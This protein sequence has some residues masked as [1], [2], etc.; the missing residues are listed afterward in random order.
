[1]NPMA[2]PLRI[3]TKFIGILI[4]A[5]VLPVTAALFVFET[6]GYRSYR[7]ARGRL[8]QARAEHLAVMLT[9]LVRQELESLEDWVALSDLHERVAQAEET[10]RSESPEERKT[11]AEAIEA[12][13]PSMDREDP[14]VRNIISNDIAGRLNAFRSLHGVFAEIF[15]TDKFGRLLAATAKTSD[16]LQAD[17]PWWQRGVALPLRSHYVEGIQ[18]DES[19]RVFSLDVALPIRDRQRPEE[20]PLGVLKGVINV[21]PLFDHADPTVNGDI[22][23]RHVVLEDGR[24]LATLYSTGA[25]PLKERVPNDVKSR[26]V[27][28][29]SGWVIAPVLGNE[30]DLIGYAP[31]KIGGTMMTGLQITG[32]TPMFVMVRTPASVVLAP[33]RQMIILLG[34]AGALILFAFIVA[35]YFVATR[36]LIGP[37]ENLR[38]AVRRIADSVKLDRNARPSPA[39]ATV[40]EPLRAIR[41]RD[42]LEDLSR[43]FSSMAQ[44]V[45]GYNKQLETEI[46]AK[47][48][49]ISRDLQLAREFQE[50]LMPHGFPKIPT[51]SAG[52]PFNLNFRHL[53]KP[54]SSVG[55][56]FFDVVK[57]DDERAGVFIA[58]VMGHGARSALVTAILRTLLQN[59]AAESAEPARFLSTLNRHFNA[60]IRNSG[61][62]IFVSAFYLVAD[63]G[64]GLMCYAS[65]GHPSPFIAKKGNGDVLPLIEHLQGNPALGILPEATYQQWTRPLQDGELYVL[66]TDGVHEAYNE[67]GE[68]YGLDRVR[69]VIL[70]Q[71]GQENADVP[72]AIVADVQQFISPALPADDI[73][74]VAIEVTANRPASNVGPI[75]EQSGKR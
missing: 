39:A 10:V 51:D 24:I 1:M 63:T 61:E 9:D 70:T 14:F 5:S 43:D 4:M 64:N 75:A 72:T 41:T 20:P 58:D 59:L 38:E 73:C 33:A 54:A 31:L 40:L 7:E 60:I 11:V 26:I 25:E 13:W 66:F 56:D 27:N 62:T 37:I 2:A 49:E 22:G 35:G 32:A 42:E 48:A 21:T 34:L 23:S 30:K 52:A 57:L 28:T 3:R 44:R 74:I 50:A 19:A 53:Y 17:E 55:G 36:K 8:H 29:Q 69:E 47:T 46:A 16:Y 71:L 18:Y 68:E 15:V 6:L 12:R 45:L 65:A 67:S